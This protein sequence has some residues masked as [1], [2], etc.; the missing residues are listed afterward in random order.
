MPTISNEDLARSINNALSEA[1]YGVSHDIIVSVAQTDE[2]RAHVNSAVERVLQAA[3]AVE[4]RD[5]IAMPPMVAYLAS[6]ASTY[7]AREYV[8]ANYAERTV[9]PPRRTIKACQEGV[10]T[11]VREAR[12]CAKFAKEQAA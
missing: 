5:G 12:M 1:D 11:I 7:A 3:G 10:E 4:T 2:F 6:K 9:L 8:C